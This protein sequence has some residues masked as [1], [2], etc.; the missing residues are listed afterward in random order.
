MKISGKA[1]EGLLTAA[2]GDPK[3]VGEEG[4]HPLGLGDSRDGLL[5]LPPAASETEHPLVLLLHGAGVNAWDIMGV[6]QDAAEKNDCAL[7]A[8]DSREDTWDVLAGGFGPDVQFIDDA[9]AH[10]FAR[11]RWIRRG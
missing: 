10:T 9:L 7:L 6:L 11:C 1:R 5:Y 2:P 3:E 8:P 4:L